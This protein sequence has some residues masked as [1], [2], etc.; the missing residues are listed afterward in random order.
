MNIC[1]RCTRYGLGFSR[2]YAPHEFIEGDPQSRVWIIGLNPAEDP[3]WKDDR[4]RSRLSSHFEGVTK[5]HPY[6]QQFRVVSERLFDMLGKKGGAAHTDLVK[7]ASRSWPPKNLKGADRA[8]II[9]NCVGYLQ[10]QIDTYEPALIVCN[11]S[12]VSAEVR[13]LLPPIADTPVNA[14]RYVHVRPSGQSV[15][16]VLSGFIGRIDNYAKR[17][18]GA[19]IEAVMPGSDPAAA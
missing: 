16:V 9:A 7:C 6:F 19:E 8:A 5:K 4:D 13:R 12:E 1:D 15:T 14:T 2:L 10:Q 3:M 17:R 11:G 18:L